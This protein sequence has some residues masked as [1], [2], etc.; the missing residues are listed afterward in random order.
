MVKICQTGLLKLKLWNH[1]KKRIFRFL[2]KISAGHAWSWNFF[3][4]NFQ[5]LGPLMGYYTS[6][7]EKMSKSLHPTAYTA[8]TS[9]GQAIFDTDIEK[10]NNNTKKKT[11]DNAKWVAIFTSQKSSLVGSGRKVCLDA[12]K[13]VLISF[14]TG[15]RKSNLKSGSECRAIK[16]QLVFT[17]YD[18]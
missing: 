14:T 6:K 9:G 1:T 5:I 2:P 11:V 10:T 4:A 17:C 13:S 3:F 16:V 8:S 15:L 12:C 7:C 18:Q